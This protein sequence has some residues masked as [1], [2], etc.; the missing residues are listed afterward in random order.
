MEWNILLSATVIAAIISGIISFSTQL[1]FEKKRVKESNQREI[2]EVDKLILHELYAPIL[3]VLSFNIF[4]GDGYEGISSGQLTDIRKILDNKSLL[5]DTE[6]AEIVYG[7]EEDLIHLWR[8]NSLS[9]YDEKCL[10]DDRKLL[11]HV[12]K[13]YNL[14]RKSLNYP[15]DKE[16]L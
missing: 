9:E 10:D 6:L 8:N 11:E 13:I 7:Y 3:D 1:F 12:N 4:P 15:Y 2:K 14:K 5:V 16:N